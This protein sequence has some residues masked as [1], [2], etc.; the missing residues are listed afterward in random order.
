VGSAVNGTKIRHSRH[1]GQPLTYDLGS[2][3][4]LIM[5]VGEV[6]HGR[7]GGFLLDLSIGW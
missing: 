3:Y 5:G 6:S 2:R 4:R 1:S 7:H